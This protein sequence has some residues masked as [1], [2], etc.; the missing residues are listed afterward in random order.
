MTSSSAA[1]VSLSVISSDKSSLLRQH[2][3]ESKNNAVSRRRKLASSVSLLQNLNKKRSSSCHSS[4]EL[5]SKRNSSS[6]D[7]DFFNNPNVIL[8]G[9]VQLTTNLQTQNRYVF[10]YNDTVIFTKQKS[11]TSYRL[12][13]RVRLCEIWVA[14]CLD[15]VAE[16]V[17]QP[18]RSFV[19]GWPTTNV[20]ATFLTPEI[21]DAWLQ[22]L[23]ECIKEEKQKEIP[24]SVLI[25]VIN[26]DKNF[27][28][29]KTLLVDNTEVAINV[30]TRCVQE[31][32]ITG[33]SPV[34]FQLWVL[35]DS[36]H[37]SPYPLIGHEQ[38]YSIRMKYLRDKQSL[39]RG[40]GRSSALE[41]TYGTTNNEDENDPKVS[42]F[43]SYTKIRAK[44]ICLA[45]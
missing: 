18:D 34:N 1:A 5:S 35:S 23:T 32:H 28:I 26:R 2:P 33:D 19:I 12:K 16:V 20:V 27:S 11:P 6:C 38:P 41:E 17:R 7:Y 8:E 44:E 42:D 21:K 15:E 36:K 30:T 14:S 4:K 29:A 25:K 39:A 3:G 22:K 13:L 31:F 37:D 9:P 43:R 45:N 24:A 40:R 10:L